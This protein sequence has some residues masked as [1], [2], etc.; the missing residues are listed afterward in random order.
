M[1][2]VRQEELHLL[3][4]QFPLAGQ[5]G[6]IK[7]INL[8]VTLDKPVEPYLCY[9]ILGPC[10]NTSEPEYAEKVGPPDIPSAYPC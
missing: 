6:M 3:S 4:L 10:G 9:K 1:I 8:P 7:A 5:T 2:K